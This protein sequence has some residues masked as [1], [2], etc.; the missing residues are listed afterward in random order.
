MVQGILRIMYRVRYRRILVR[1]VNARDYID[2]FIVSAAS[3]VLLVRFWLH[4]LDYP[5]IGGAKYHI[6]HLLWGGLA[7]A[8][9]FML[10]FAYLGKR[11]QWV[12]AALGGF[13]FGVFLDEIGK[14][15][16]RDNDYF[17]RPAIGI[18]YAVF[19]VLYLFGTFLARKTVLNSQEYQLNA[20]YQLE[21]AGQHDMNQRERTAVQ[22]LLA[23]SNPN[24]VLTQRLQKL[25]DRLP[26]TPLPPPSRIARLRG[27]LAEWYDSMWESRS[28]NVAVRWFFV[29]ETLVFLGAVIVALYTNVDDVQDFFAGRIQYGYSLVVGQL[30]STVIAATCVVIG[31][32]LLQ[33]SRLRALEWFRRATLVHLLLTDFF[34]F[35][36]LQFEALPS[37]IF[38][39]AV[40]VM[41]NIA[42]AHEHQFERSA[43]KALPAKT[44][45]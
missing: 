42:L 39:V 14:F 7:M 30:L 28:S 34:L 35:G 43:I 20:L 36:R 17:F 11:V 16:T 33:R 44:S 29:L 38:H 13:G 9:A 27:S 23:R 37:F 12:V 41:L 26:V 3:A 22:A 31:L 32:G 10:N 21:E 24:D 19:V 15:V 40:L 4:L 6:G 18:I 45:L 1:N 5:S 25:V 8:L 2:T